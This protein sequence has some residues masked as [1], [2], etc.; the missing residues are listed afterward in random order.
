MVLEISFVFEKCRDSMNNKLLPYVSF[1]FKRN[2]C[3]NRLLKIFNCASSI[4]NDTARKWSQ[5]DISNWWDWSHTLLS[6]YLVKLCF[7]SY[8]PNT[9]YEKKFYHTI[10]WKKKSIRTCSAFPEFY[11]YV[12]HI[13]GSTPKKLIW[14]WQRVSTST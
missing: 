14:F 6:V 1:V 10:V 4:N 2:K 13:E 8:I 7:L 9:Q 3:S 11:K 5:I 12:L